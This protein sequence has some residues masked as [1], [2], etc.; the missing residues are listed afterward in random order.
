MGSN[1][2]QIV[3]DCTLVEFSGIFPL[4]KYLF[5][6]LYVYFIVFIFYRGYVILGL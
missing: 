5:I 4:L 1:E 3:R 2:A 6:L